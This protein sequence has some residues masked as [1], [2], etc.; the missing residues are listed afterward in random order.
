MATSALGALL[1]V[2]LATPPTPNVYHVRWATTLT[3]TVVVCPVLIFLPAIA[4]RITSLALI[5][6]LVTTSI[7]LTCVSHALTLAHTATPLIVSAAM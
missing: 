3:S 5:V 1:P 7:V 2:L 4:V 6:C